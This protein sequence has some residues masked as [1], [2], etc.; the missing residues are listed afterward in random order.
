LVGLFGVDE[1]G[2]IRG[3]GAKSLQEAFGRLGRLDDSSAE[4]AAGKGQKEILACFQELKLI[5]RD[6]LCRPGLGAT[7]ILD[8]FER[9]WEVDAEGNIIEA[10]GREWALKD[11]G[12]EGLAALDAIGKSREAVV[13]CLASIGL[14]NESGKL[15]AEADKS[16]IMDL[17]RSICATR[18]GRLVVDNQSTEELAVRKVCG[19]GTSEVLRE[20]KDSINSI[21]GS[22]CL[23]SHGK[24]KNGYTKKHMV[25]MI[26]DFWR[27]GPRGSIEQ[28][29]ILTKEQIKKQLRLYKGGK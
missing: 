11:Y 13:K 10:A 15:L 16:R 14:A 26:A 27:V 6:G 25:D 2:G 9:M 17:L 3:T 28:S 4:T 21:L 18:R 1:T 22:R 8:A 12:V 20:T 24:V 23:D 29:V 7:D 19:W 5:E